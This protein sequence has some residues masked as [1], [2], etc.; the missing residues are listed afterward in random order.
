MTTLNGFGRLGG[1]N[2]GYSDQKIGEVLVYATDTFT[3]TQDLQIQSYLALKYG[4]HL[5]QT[6]PVSYLA[7]DGTTLMWN[8]D[9]IVTEATYITDIFGIGRDDNSDLMQL[10]SKSREQNDR[11]IITLS[12]TSGTIPNDKAFMTIADNLGSAT[13]GTA[14]APSGYQ[15]LGKRWQ[16]Q[17]PAGDVGPVTLQIDMADSQ[18]NVAN[19]SNFYLMIDTDSD[20]TYFDETVVGGGLIRLYDDGT[21]GD[22]TADDNIWS[23]NNVEF[24]TGTTNNQTR[25][26]IGTRIQGPGGVTTGLM[27]WL[28]ASDVNA[29]GDTTNNPADNSQMNTNISTGATGTGHYW[30]DRSPNAQN[31]ITMNG[32]CVYESDAAN[33]ALF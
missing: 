18:F 26:T 30:T 6:N 28:N 32:A 27:T 31:I 29:D 16:V 33:L 5:D 21:N 3:G 12:T 4:M 19:A 10:K 2:W 25:F 13:F 9:S 20:G 7:S 22:V 8:S 23:I 17:E 15:I 14:Q 1:G 24:P 11:G